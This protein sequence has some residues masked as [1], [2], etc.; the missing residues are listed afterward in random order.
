[1]IIFEFKKKD[2]GKDS[3][4]EKSKE[5]ELKEKYGVIKDIPERKVEAEGIPFQHVVHPKEEGETKLPDLL[6]RI[7]KMDGKLDVIDRF[8]DDVNER[9]TH[10]AEEIGELRT[11]VMERD[12]SYDEVTT[13]FEKVRDTVSGLEP[14]KLKKYFEKKEKEIIENKAKIERIENLVKA[15]GEESKKFRNVMERIKSFENLIDVSYDIDRKI[16]KIKES[17]DHV[18]M[19]VSKIENIFSEMNDKVSEL[20]SQR[21]KINKLDGLTIE[22]TKML[23]EVSV[24]LNRFVEKKD[25]GELKKY[26]DEDLKKIEASLKGKVPS[27][28]EKT[29]P[30]TIPIPDSKLTELYSQISKL[31]SIVD[32]QNMAIKNIISRLGTSQIRSGRLESSLEIRNVKLSLRFFQI[33]NILMFESNP[34]KIK[35]YLSEVKEIAQEMKSNGIWNEE[36]ERYMREILNKLSRRIE[37]LGSRKSQAG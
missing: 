33:M 6:L 14:M 37:P 31:K 16:S 26:L 35:G 19:A 8:R 34:M 23:D 36:K 30:I 9:I 22:M 15:L 13:Q 17:K 20:E 32:S 24:R 18:D 25:I 10:L 3:K 2:V 7:E 4:S 5:E 27:V 29:V 11:M 1:M 12:R 28:K 21:E